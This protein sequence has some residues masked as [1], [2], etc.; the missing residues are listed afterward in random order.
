MTNKK[1]IEKLLDQFEDMQ[2]NAGFSEARN[3]P[4]ASTQTDQNKIKE[5]ILSLIK[6]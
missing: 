6:D 4:A 5:K 1:Q 3:L 2:F